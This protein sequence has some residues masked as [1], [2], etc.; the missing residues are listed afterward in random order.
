MNGRVDAGVG[1]R[2]VASVLVYGMKNRR[3]LKT[4]MALVC[5][6]PVKFKVYKQI[7]NAISPAFFQSFLSSTDTLWFQP[8]FRPK[9]WIENSATEFIKY[10]QI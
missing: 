9:F 7:I 2:H 3:G 8:S 10:Y 4:L 1:R 5:I 6:L